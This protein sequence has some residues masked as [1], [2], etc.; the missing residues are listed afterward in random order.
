MRARLAL[1]ALAAALLGGCAASGHRADTVP[2]TDALLTLRG[3]M[4]GAFS[5]RAQAE[6]DPSY[7]HLVMHATPMW[8]WRDDGPWLYVEQAVAETP[9]RPYRQRVYKLEYAGDGRLWAR[10]FVL[11]DPGPHAGAFKVASPLSELSPDDLTERVGCAVPLAWDGDA[12]VFQ[13]ATTGTGC[14]SDLSGAAYST[15][16]VT[17][18]PERI[19]SW[20]RGFDATGQLV[21]GAATGGYEFVRTD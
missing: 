17:I 19:V 2:A 9:D 1:A 10:V 8:T 13:G 3:W 12:G 20:E 5:T 11:D 4:S 6:R 7:Y 18:G 21:W 15:S 16:V 14:P